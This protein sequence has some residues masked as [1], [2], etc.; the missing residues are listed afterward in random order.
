MGEDP[1]RIRTV[2]EPDAMDWERMRVA[3]W[4]A[5]PGEHAADIAAFFTG[6]RVNPAE[7]FVALDTDGHPIGFAEMSIRHYAN[8][9]R[10]GRVAFLEG[11]FVD[12]PHR[13]NGV[14]VALINAVEQWGREQGCSELASDCELDNAVSIAVHLA[15]SFTEVARTVCFKKLL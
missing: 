12:E 6:N 14:A 3:L 5:D 7:V 13:R 1:I 15:A 4:S 11:L 10:T 8:G 2:Q 9:C